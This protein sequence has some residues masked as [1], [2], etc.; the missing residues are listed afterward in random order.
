MGLNIV[1]T[2][3]NDRIAT[4]ILNRLGRDPD[5]HTDFCPAK[6]DALQEEMASA[7]PD[8]IVICLQKGL[9]GEIEIYD[10]LRDYTEL[11]MR[12]I[13]IAEGIEDRKQFQKKSAL[14]KPVFLTTPFSMRLL[15]EALAAIEND[16]GRSRIKQTA[17]KHILVVDDDSSQLI[18]IR[19]HL[20][21]FFEA[22]L[23][24]SG[25]NALKYLEKRRPDLILL[26]YKMPD[27]D[28]PAVMRLLR[29]NPAYRDIPVV[30][31]TGVSEKELVMQ[32]ILEFRPQ[33][34][35]LKPTKKSELLAK[36]V[37]VLG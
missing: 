37:D 12:A 24:S 10:V 27:L 16:L 17:R 26:D 1:L 15:Y 7:R 23:V 5:H 29:E 22:T 6:R 18:Q 36:L 13:V 32:A 31:L 3:K 19:E 11:G 4:G 14:E 34:Y 9:P 28:G 2:G 33:G 21:E 20:K 30:F 25:K 35:L 8:V